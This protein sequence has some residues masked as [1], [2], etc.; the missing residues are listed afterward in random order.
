MRKKLYISLSL[1]LLA[2]TGKITAQGCVAIRQMGG[3]TAISPS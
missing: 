3:V 1:A 2:C